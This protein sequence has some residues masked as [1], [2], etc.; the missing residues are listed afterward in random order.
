MS[1]YA[2]HRPFKS[3]KRFANHYKDAPINESTK[4]FATLIEGMDKSLG[5]IVEHLKDLKIADNTL[6][7]FLR[8]DGSTALIGDPRGYG[9]STPLKREK[10]TGY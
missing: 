7:L 10:G 2:V 9:S 8:D 5:D 3:D 1:H 4:K 6:I